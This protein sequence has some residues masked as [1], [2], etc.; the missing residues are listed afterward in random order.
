M[1]L[2]E[3]NTYVSNPNHN[4]FFDATI[5]NLMKTRKIEENATQKTFSNRTT[6]TRTR[7]VK[8]SRLT[9]CEK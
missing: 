1:Y 8:I 3:R 9:C 7:E 2:V 6:M 5:S 4:C